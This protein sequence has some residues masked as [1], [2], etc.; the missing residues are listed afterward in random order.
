VL[1]SELGKLIYT[2]SRSCEETRMNPCG[3]CS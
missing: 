1:R 2:R 3:N